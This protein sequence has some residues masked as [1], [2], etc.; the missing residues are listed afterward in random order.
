MNQSQPWIFA[1][2][3]FAQ[4]LFAS[5]MIIQW[6]K[7]EKAGKSISPTVF[8]QLSVLGSAIFLL[9]GILRK[10]FAIVLGQCLVYYIYIRNLHLKNFWMLLPL[11]F[12]VI[13][14]IIP[15]VTL[16]Y[17][18]SGYPGNL[19]EIF[20]Y[21]DIP[22]WLKIWGSIG[23][24]VFT[25]RFYIQLIDS[26][27]I[28]QSVFSQRF[29]IISLAGSVMIITYAV[30]RRDPVL[31]LGQLAGMIVYIRNLAISNKSENPY[32]LSGEGVINNNR[33]TK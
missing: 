18:L 4:L 26:E 28:K 32:S 10:D 5:R 1:I 14:L 19:I 9:Y 33:E 27:S 31:F 3:F 13:V 16:G 24:I 25:L 20:S 15:V 22:L 23:Q 21:K 29:W 11:W 8:W 7:S 6:V 17:L 12:R 30:F 2:G